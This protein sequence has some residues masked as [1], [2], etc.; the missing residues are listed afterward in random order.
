MS[1][2]V[3]ARLESLSWLRHGF[4]T[5]HCGAWTP[6]ERTALLHQVHGAAV[7]GVA[8]PGHHGDGDALVTAEPALWLEIRTA[9][10]VPVLLADTRRH[11]VA[12]V[13]AGWRGTAA[14]IAS[15]TVAVMVREWG[16]RA[17]D[18]IAAIGPCI[19]PCCFEVGEEVAAHFPGHI[20]QREP[21]YR[22]NL[23]GAN[24][25]QL[26]D[27]GVPERN[28]EVLGQCTVCDAGRFHSFRRDKGT[29]RMVAAIAI[30]AESDS[31]D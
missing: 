17:A 13:H 6:P 18:I 16:C 10:C 5:R 14:R 29:G 19:A 31:K 30:L 1:R 9:D 24:L 12:A 8:T 7:V 2:L 21:R 25:D 27:C 3:S 11:V 20:T 26:R 23:P 28:I 4:G 22:V 15:E